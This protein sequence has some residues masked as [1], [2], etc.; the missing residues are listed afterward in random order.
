MRAFVI[1]IMDTTVRLS[2][3]NY[4]VSVSSYVSAMFHN[5]VETARSSCAPPPLPPP[6]FLPVSLPV[7]F[8]RFICQS[9]FS[10]C[11]SVISPIA[12]WSKKRH[13][14]LWRKMLI[15]TC[16]ST[17]FCFPHYITQCF[18]FL[19]FVVISHNIWACKKQS[20]IGYNGGSVQGIN[21]KLGQVQPGH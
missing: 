19:S 6:T 3:A 17:S 1:V 13:S 5:H 16:D 12:R 18:T 15:N 10:K 8:Y 7:C 14:S 11:H 20:C 9:T 4:C 2:A 21:C